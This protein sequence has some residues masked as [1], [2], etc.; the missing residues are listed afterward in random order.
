MLMYWIKKFYSG[1]SKNQLKIIPLFL[2]N[3]KSLYLGMIY[4]SETNYTSRVADCTELHLFLF[5]FSATLRKIVTKGKHPS[6]R[7]GEQR[8]LGELMSFSHSSGNLE[9]I[10]FNSLKLSYG[11]ASVTKRSTSLD[12]I[13]ELAASDKRYS[14]RLAKF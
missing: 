6:A 9:S 8:V 12:K 7:P 11:L 2:I 14:R 1:V 13:V 3:R 10:S 4:T 5:F